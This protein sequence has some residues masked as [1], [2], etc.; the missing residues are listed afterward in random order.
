MV[1]QSQTWDSEKSTIMSRIECN[2]FIIRFDKKDYKTTFMLKPF[3]LV[4]DPILQ[5]EAVVGWSP[6]PTPLCSLVCS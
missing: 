5:L 3:E 1:C 6:F 4:R 2:I